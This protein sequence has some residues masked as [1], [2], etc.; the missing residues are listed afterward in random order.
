MKNK[1]TEHTH[2]NALI[3]YLTINTY[4]TQ[5]PAI[6]L[7]HGTTFWKSIKTITAHIVKKQ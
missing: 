4:S 2:R 6:L 5:Y 1:Y 7:Q 3:L